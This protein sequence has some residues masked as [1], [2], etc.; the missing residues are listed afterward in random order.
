MSNQILKYNLTRPMAWK[1]L[2]FNPPL[3]IALERKKFQFLN[4]GRI[5]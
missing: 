3:E 1:K 5:M 4:P 2:F